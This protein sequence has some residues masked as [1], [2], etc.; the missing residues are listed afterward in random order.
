MHKKS[1]IHKFLP[2]PLIKTNQSYFSTLHQNFRR[3]IEG[4]FDFRNIFFLDDSIEKNDKN[5]QENHIIVNTY[6]YVDP[7]T[8]PKFERKLRVPPPIFTFTVSSS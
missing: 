7:S 5:D 1:V 8:H 6:W 3:G 4:Q 2:K